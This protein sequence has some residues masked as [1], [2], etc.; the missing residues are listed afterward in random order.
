MPGINQQKK[1]IWGLL[2]ALFNRGNIFFKWCFPFLVYL[3]STKKL[4]G[5]K[6]RIAQP[7]HEKFKLIMINF[8]IKLSI[9]VDD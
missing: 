5:E 8:K 4:V 2:L 3:T 6:N 9:K 1:L 7:T